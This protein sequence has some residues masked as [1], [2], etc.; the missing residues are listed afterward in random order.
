METELKFRINGTAS[1]DELERIDWMPYSL[2]ELHVHPLHDVVLDTADRLITGSKHA[3][4][5]RHDADQVYLTFKGPQRASTSGSFQREELESAIAGDAEGDRS[6]WPVLIQD[7]VRALIG[8][9]ELEPIVEVRNERIAWEVRLDGRVVA[10][11]A[12]DKGEI[13]AGDARQA[14]HEIEIE[15]KGEGT[16]ADLDDLARRL[17][18]VLP[19]EPETRSKLERGLEL[20]ARAPSG[21]MHSR[22]ELAEAGRALLHKH[23]EK[24]RE[25]EPGV[26]EGDHEAVHDMRVATRRLRAMLEVLGGTVYDPDETVQLRRGLRRLARALGAVRDVEVWLDAV[27]AYAGH[28]AD[29]ERAGLDSLTCELHGRRDQG[30]EALLTELDGKRTAKLFDRLERFVSTAGAGVR[31]TATAPGGTPLR[32]RDVAGSV[33]WARLEEVQAF[34]PAI[35]EASIE[36]LHELRIAGKH[37]RYTLDLFGDALGGDGK[38]LRSELVEVQDQLGALHDADVALP[39]VGQLLEQEPENPGLRRYHAHLIAERD[40]LRS[41]TGQSWEVIGRSGF[42]R[43]LAMTI[44][45]I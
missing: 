14:L 10:E 17:H 30:R 12:L 7:Q 43:R 11:I 26:R 35:P 8:E 1:A 39:L 27:H 6:Q 28:L 18:Q 42:R 29:D 34:E 19:L 2:G 3:L 9:R 5:V 31:P 45:S 38:A 41:A 36:L 15:R 33:L 22:A 13:R 44:A 24:L 40:R 23:Y 37:L 4:R 20:R 21:A 16:E 25:A 32:V